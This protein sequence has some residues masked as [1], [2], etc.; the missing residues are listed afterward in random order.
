MLARDPDQPDEELDV[1]AIADY[2]NLSPTT[3]ADVLGR[4]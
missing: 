1:D 4:T 2:R 3:L